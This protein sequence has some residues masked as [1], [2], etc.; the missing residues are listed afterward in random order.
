MKCQDCDTVCIEERSRPVPDRMRE[1]IRLSRKIPKNMDD[2]NKLE[3]SSAIA[4]HAIEMNHKV[5]FDEPEILSQNWQIYRERI[6]AEQ[7]HIA[8]EPSAC[9][10]QKKPLH[11]AWNTL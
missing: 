5:N 4:L 10:C 3:R 11:P 7:W 1:H 9:N 8:L 6:A 2:R